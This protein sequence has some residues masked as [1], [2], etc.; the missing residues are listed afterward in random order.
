MSKNFSV[1]FTITKIDDPDIEI[2]ESNNSSQTRPESNGQ[3][4]EAAHPS[5][6]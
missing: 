2:K 6:T 3:W 4:H 5:P 1:S